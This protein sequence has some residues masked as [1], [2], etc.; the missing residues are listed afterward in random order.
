MSQRLIQN[1]PGSKAVCTGTIFGQHLYELRGATP[2]DDGDDEGGSASG[3]GDGGDGGTGTESSGSENGESGS[4]SDQDGEDVDAVK[5]RMQAADRRASKAEAR[6]KELEEAQL[7]ADQKKDKELSELRTFKE[8]APK[9][10][11]NLEA[12]VAFLSINDVSWNDPD[13]ALGQLK[14]SEVIDEDGQIDKAALKK[15][16][17]KLAK[18]KPF[19]VKTSTGG[20]SG[21]GAGGGSGAGASGGG[22]GSGGKSSKNNGVLSDEELRRRYPA[23]NV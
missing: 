11:A 15:A 13:I 18:E 22:V 5:A 19:L 21:G 12:K 6:V 20:D 23:L 3:S 4:G 1:I 17:E 7:T 2:N 8:E 9:V 16:V 14:L 10:I